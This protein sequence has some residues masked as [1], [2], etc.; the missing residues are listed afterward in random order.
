MFLALPDSALRLQ[1]ERSDPCS[2]VGEMD[3]KVHGDNRVE[4][5]VC[6]AT[7]IP[8]LKTRGCDV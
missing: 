7:G 1:G 6:F 2:Y 3:K 5:V 8:A 4:L